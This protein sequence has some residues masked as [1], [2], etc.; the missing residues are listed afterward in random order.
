[1]NPKTHLS[2]P[3][4]NERKKNDAPKNNFVAL[5]IFPFT[6]RNIHVN[7]RLLRYKINIFL[8]KNSISENALKK[9][10]CS[11]YESRKKSI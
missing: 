2:H 4:L 6:I 8:L 9:E 5:T 10:N 7:G 1:M 11:E 3:V